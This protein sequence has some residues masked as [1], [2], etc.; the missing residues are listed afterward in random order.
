MPRRSTAQGF[1]TFRSSPELNEKLDGEVQRLRDEGLPPEVANRSAVARALLLGALGT[2]AN[3][4]S[5]SEAIKRVF[6][7]VKAST[8]RAMSELEDRLPEIVDEE[9]GKFE[10]EA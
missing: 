3:R 6:G 1:V 2:D 9:L 8:A 5:G 4:V 7:I 10:V